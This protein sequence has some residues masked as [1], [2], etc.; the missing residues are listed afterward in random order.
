MRIPLHVVELVVS[1]FVFSAYHWVWLVQDILMRQKKI[2]SF[3]Y[4]RARNAARQQK[5]YERLKPGSVGT[6]SKEEVW[7]TAA[8]SGVSENIY[9]TAVHRFARAF[10]TP[11][12]PLLNA[13]V[14]QPAAL[15]HNRGELLTS[16]VP[17]V[18]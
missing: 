3:W 11:T 1:V 18:T 6:T 7:L 13:V 15:S 9:C 5:Q 2:N 14:V 10:V 16:S 8:S 12:R 17:I 4:V